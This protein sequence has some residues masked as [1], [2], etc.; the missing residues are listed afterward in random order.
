[1]ATS[2]YCI[3]DRH[4]VVPAY[5]FMNCVS[6]VEVIDPISSSRPYTVLHMHEYTMI[7]LVGVGDTYKCTDTGSSLYHVT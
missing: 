1:M 7:L 2:S 5:S 6:V 3:I 4:V